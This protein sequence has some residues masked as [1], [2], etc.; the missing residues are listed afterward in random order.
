MRRKTDITKQSTKVYR[1]KPRSKKLWLSAICIPLA[2]GF[3][4]MSLVLLLLRYLPLPEQSLVNPTEIESDD[5]FR[6][7]E[8]TSTGTDEQPVPLSRIPKAL[9]DA[10]LAVED[11]NFYHDHAIDLKST[12]RAMLVNLRHGQVVEGGSTITQQLAKNLFLTQD[13]T[14]SRKIREALFAIQLE[15]H[16]PKDW[17]L[18]RYLNVVYYGHGAYGVQSAAHLYFNKSVDDLNLAECAMLAGLPKGPSIY[19]PLTDMRLAKQRQHVVLSRMVQAGYL[20]K[21][22]AAAAY[23]TPIHIATYHTPVV[24]APYFTAVAVNEAKRQFQIS[25]EHLYQGD[26]RIH[27]TLDPLLQQAAERAIQTT[28]PK[29]S[30]IQ[31][32]L[33]ALD[34]HTG[35]IKA[36]V[37]GRDFQTSPFNRAMAPRQ[38]GSTFKG[39]LYTA[40]LENSWTPANQVDSKL[41]TFVY[42]PNHDKQYTVHDYGDF[43][44][45]RPLTLREA[46]ARSDNVYAVHTNLT[47]GPEKVVEMAHRMGI[48]SSLKP[49]PSLAL[50]VFPV[51]PLELA[52]AYATLA[53][54]GFRVTPYAVKEIDAPGNDMAAHPAPERVISPQIAYQMTDLLT[55]VLQRNGTGYSVHD[56]LHDVAA[57]KTGTT[58][59]DA[60]MVGYTPNLVCAV[61]VGYDSNRPLTVAESHLASPIWAKFMGTAQTHLPY[62]WYQ[63]APGLKA[64]T[65]DPLTGK[66]ATPLCRTTEIDYFVP[67]TEP[68]SPCPVHAPAQPE[69]KST[70]KQKLFGWFQKWF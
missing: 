31:A 4:G 66:L 58:D 60:W 20:T 48:Q 22:Q 3:T 17:I 64:Y 29:G 8:W 5:G 19:S 25:T 67:G 56:Y 69:P 47:I 30:A 24:R 27:T 63:P 38:P 39:I 68:S 53:N 49:Y 65:L 15:L 28:L 50:G 62:Q 46:L 54:G 23:R 45:E 61:W 6:L 11:T 1:R 26:L 12:A 41:T 7:A 51:S 40:A 43:Y 52:T 42:G 59:T 33:V 44:A 10:T 35:A 21:G 9:V 18:N 16:E 2:T 14:Y 34:P 37:G 55:S 70:P 32:A 13:R 36:L 57:A